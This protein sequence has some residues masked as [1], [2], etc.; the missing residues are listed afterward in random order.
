MYRKCLAVLASSLLAIPLVASGQARDTVPPGAP[1]APSTGTPQEIRSPGVATLLSAVAPGSGQMYAGR[2][3]LG[4]G[5]LVFTGMSLIIAQS[6]YATTD[7]SSTDNTVAAVFTAF[8]AAGWG[9][10]VYS[11]GGDV[12]EYNRRHQQ[13][14]M[15]LRPIIQLGSAGKFGR[16]PNKL[17]LSVEL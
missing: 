8:T 11:A 10:S 14:A 5:L 16:T 3:G 9:Y 1:T 17:G 13:H 12:E 15:R 2:P 7:R 6:E 4:I